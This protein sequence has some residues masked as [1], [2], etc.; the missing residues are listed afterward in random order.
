[1]QVSGRTAVLVLIFFAAG[2]VVGWL[3]AAG[4]RAPHQAGI[5]SVP[6]V[7]GRCY[8]SGL[9]LHVVPVRGPGMRH[10]A[11]LC[12]TPHGLDTLEQRRVGNW[13]DWHD[14]VKVQQVAPESSYGAE[15]AWRRSGNAVRLG[16]VLLM[17]DRDLLAEVCAALWE[18]RVASD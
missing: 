7:V 18:G 12:R 8:S 10:G 9:E 11:Y 15:S 14:V 1:V 13:D 16:P 3:G 17:G 5:D 6:D 2:V 4:R